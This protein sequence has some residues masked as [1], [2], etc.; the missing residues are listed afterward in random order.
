M[1]RVYQSSWALPPTSVTTLASH[2]VGVIYSIGW[3]G[4]TANFTQT[5]GKSKWKTIADGGQDSGTNGLIAQIQS[6]ASTASTHKVPID[7]GLWH[8]PGGNW[9]VGHPK[10]DSCSTSGCDGSS[11]EYQAMYQHL[12]DLVGTY[13]N[14]YTRVIYIE[15]DS[16]IKLATD[17]NRPA[18]T[19]YDLLGP[20][21]YNYY[22][23]QSA[24]AWH[25][26]SDSGKIGSYP[27]TG[28]L[29]LAVAHSKHIVFPEVGTH[30][31]CPGGWNTASSGTAEDS[32]CLS[33]DPAS[34]TKNQYFQDL[35]KLLT[36]TGRSDA[37][38]IETWI[39][40]F[41]YY[42]HVATHDWEFVNRE[43]PTYNYESNTSCP[44]AWGRTCWNG[45]YDS[46]GD[47]DSNGWGTSFVTDSASYNHNHSN[48][49]VG[50][51]SGTLSAGR[52]PIV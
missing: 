51:T 17:P 40:G 12:H 27:G 42:H 35:A 37:A 31:G 9:S 50:A 43:A 47:H 36:D 19:A 48:W 29:A 38:Q 6:L 26:A 14:A 44:S 2:N 52:A 39:E 13:G 16:T 3:N 23:W 20:D 10:V 45:D 11:T 7:I 30:P 22:V 34:P 46:S 33:T 41:V 5:T 21:L 25:Y 4:T 1:D 18:D 8:E 32:G 28:I 49:F 24:R 15:V